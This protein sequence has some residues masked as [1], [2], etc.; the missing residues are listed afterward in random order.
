M[1][2][3]AVIEKILYKLQKV[4]IIVKDIP[5]LY[6]DL[7]DTNQLEQISFYHG[8]TNPNHRK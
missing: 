6:V 3:L 8:P 2:L 7:E 4:N 1:K 5:R